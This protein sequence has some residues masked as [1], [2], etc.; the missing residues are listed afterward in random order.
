MKKKEEKNSEESHSIKILKSLKKASIP[1][2]AL[3]FED[4]IEIGKLVK[5]TPGGVLLFNKH[6]SEPASLRVQGVPFAKGKVV[7]SGESYGLQVEEILS[8]KS[9]DA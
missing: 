3:L 2:D 8:D 1:I 7:K 4:R 9:S 6:E 5:L